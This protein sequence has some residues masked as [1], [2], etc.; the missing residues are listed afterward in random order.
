MV[1]TEFKSFDNWIVGKY[2]SAGED[3]YLSENP[4][5]F[6]MYHASEL[7]KVFQTEYTKNK[8]L[9]Y[10]TFH[11]IVENNKL[12]EVLYHRELTGET[13][14][15]ISEYLPEIEQATG[16]KFDLIPEGSI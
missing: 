9:D 2:T 16:L 3:Y 1:T 15:D 8:V 14:L 13:I 5:D 7:F 11:L 6:L 12:F 4:N 10:N